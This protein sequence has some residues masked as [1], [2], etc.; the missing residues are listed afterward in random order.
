MLADITKY[1]AAVD[2]EVNQFNAVCVKG[3]CACCFH[4]IYAFKTERKLI[5]NYIKQMG[6][7]QLNTI[8]N[9]C[10]NWLEKSKKSKLIPD[11]KYITAIDLA[12]LNKKYIRSNIK[13][14]FLMNSECSI[15]EVRPLVCRT[16][17]ATSERTD[18]RFGNV[19]QICDAYR[20]NKLAE[21]ARVELKANP[22]KNHET[23]LPMG[24]AEF[25]QSC[26]LER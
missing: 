5:E 18:C 16:Y 21:F 20:L 7:N 19:E 4:P 14:P 23:L 8:R 6:T 11:S 9:N 26:L 24:F 25:A 12:Q 1:L 15:Y 22:Q 3:C 13:C 10:I 17:F 2:Q